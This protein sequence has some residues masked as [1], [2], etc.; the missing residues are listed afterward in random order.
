MAKASEKQIGF[1]LGM[2]GANGFSTEIMTAKYAQLGAVPQ[3][4]RGEVTHWLRSMTSV[5]IGAL[6]DVL[7]ARRGYI[8]KYKRPASQRY[9]G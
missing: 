3:G 2:L 1:A 8:P 7:I 6:I 4:Y 5:E 9:P